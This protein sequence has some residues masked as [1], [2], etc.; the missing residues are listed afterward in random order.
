V[1]FKGQFRLKNGVYCY[2]LTI[3]D[4]FSR[5]LIRVEALEGTSTDP[6]REVFADAFTEHGL[7][8]LIR[9]DN[10]PPFASTGLAG[11]SQLS[12]WWKRCGIE[13]ERIEPGHPEQNGQHERMHLT[14]K[15]ETTRPAAGN[16]LQQQESF[17]R[18]RDVFNN[19]RPH[20]ALGQRP[21]ATV[22][23]SSERAYRGTPKLEYP[24]HDDTRRLNERGKL[25]LNG[26]LHYV[27]IALAG[28]VVGL[29]EVEDGRWMVTFMNVDLG[30]VDE[31][32]K[33]FE[34]IA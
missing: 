10:G 8:G 29:R 27:G 9:S 31:Q 24:L 30:V 17:D 15:R 11:L 1:D 18:F 12:V 21:P 23:R 25:S 16:A 33:R 32:A 2:P 14:L 22:Y 19:E 7:P 28:E 5:Y 13:L 6:A 26:V 3:T 4:L 34:V 20:E